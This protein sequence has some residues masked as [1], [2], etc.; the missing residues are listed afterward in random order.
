MNDLCQ[1]SLHDY[2]QKLEFQFLEYNDRLTIY[3]WL[4][5]NQN[6]ISITIW[7]FPA[8][9]KSILKNLIQS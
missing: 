8:L 4:K 6:M 5:V 1:Y 3:I 2:F 7:N 9:R